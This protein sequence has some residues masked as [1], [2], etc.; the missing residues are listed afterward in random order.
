VGWNLIRAMWVGIFAI[1]LP[2]GFTVEA[3][4]QAVSKTAKLKSVNL[5]ALTGAERERYLAAHNA[6]RREVGVEAVEWSDE[7]SKDALEALAEQKE[8]LVEAAKEGWVKGKAVLPRH[9]ADSSYG[10]N[11]AGWA[12]TGPQTADWAVA[13]W[14]REK[15]DFEKL[16]ANAPYRVGDE[17]DQFE[18]DAEGNKRPIVVGH[19]TAIVWRATKRIGAAKLCFELT[20]DEGNRR[21]YLAIVCSYSPPGNRQG[22]QPF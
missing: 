12:G 17:K 22:A 2:I 15:A 14:L 21:T 6:A 16:N 13:L 3:D 9:R 8:A 7:L 5:S 4:S 10:E 19:Y 18:E 20:D 11:V 1:S